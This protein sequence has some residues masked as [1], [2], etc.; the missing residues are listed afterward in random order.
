LRTDPN[1]VGA[2]IPVYGAT[3]FVLEAGRFARV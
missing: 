2:G 1:P 3:V